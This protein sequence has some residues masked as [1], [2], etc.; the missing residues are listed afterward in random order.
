MPW[1]AY[2]GRRW[3]ARCFGTVSPSGPT[4]RSPPTPTLPTR[5]RAPR[6]TRPQCRRAPPLVGGDGGGGLAGS[7]SSRRR[8]RGHRQRGAAPRCHEAA[9]HH[10]G[11]DPRRLV[12]LV[13]ASA[14]PAQ[15]PCRKRWGLSS[16]A[17]PPTPQPN[18]PHKGEAAQPDQARV[19]RRKRGHR[20]RGA[21]PRCHEAAGDHSGRDL[22]RLV[23]LVRAS[24][25][26]TRSPC[27]KRWGLSSFAPPPTPTLPTR[28]RA[29]RSTR[30]PCWR[31][32]PLVGGDGGGGL[33]GSG[34]GSTA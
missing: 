29:P 11:R 3:F 7:G 17:P 24:T 6:S 32:P 25:H 21:A 27:R 33:A 28:G 34:S 30:S 16:V 12:R 31:A 4:A 19:R 8:K 2:R 14:H 1:R 22:R 13:R 18:P 20:Q 26:P 10:P 9:G 23:R 15:S 5:G